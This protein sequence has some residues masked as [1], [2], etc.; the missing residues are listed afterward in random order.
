VRTRAGPVMGR[1][2]SNSASVTETCASVNLS[3]CLTCP[4]SGNVRWGCVRAKGENR[5]NV[6][7]N[8]PSAS[9]SPGNGNPSVIGIF[10]PK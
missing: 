6:K 3:F 9:A 2:P 4:R 5:K 1:R 8:A 10:S 7:K